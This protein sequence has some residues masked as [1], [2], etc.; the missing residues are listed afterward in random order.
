MQRADNIASENHRVLELLLQ[1]LMA[2]IHF[3][4]EHPS[5]GGSLITSFT[6][7]IVDSGYM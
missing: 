6:Q 7:E 2:Q 3:C 1:G 5:M 4:L